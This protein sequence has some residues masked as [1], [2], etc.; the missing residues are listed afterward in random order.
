M[1]PF[2]RA[3]RRTVSRIPRG[4]TIAYH[5]ATHLHEQI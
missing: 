3:V 2:L 4:T 5:A 1:T